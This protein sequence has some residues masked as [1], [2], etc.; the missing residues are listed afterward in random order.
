LRNQRVQHFEKT[1]NGARKV[2]VLFPDSDDAYILEGNYLKI[3]QLADGT[4]GEEGL[5]AVDGE[6]YSEMAKAGLI[7]SCEL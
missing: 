7:A 2:Y 5:K 3:W 6:A 4:V 1:E